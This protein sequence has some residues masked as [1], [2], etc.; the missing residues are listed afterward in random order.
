MISVSTFF[1]TF[2]FLLNV[3]NYESVENIITNVEKYWKTSFVKLFRHII[4]ISNTHI[5]K[6]RHLF[7]IF[8]SY[9]IY[10]YINTKI[11][12]YLLWTRMTNFRYFVTKKY[13]KLLNMKI[14]IKHNIVYISWQV[15]RHFFD[16][17]FLNNEN[18]K[19]YRQKMSQNIEY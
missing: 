1:S 5:T 8:L 6:F 9:V 7:D 10:T 19:K 14:I 15:F 3:E 11:L 2:F 4:Y 17:H 18:Y 12:H 16:N 13:H